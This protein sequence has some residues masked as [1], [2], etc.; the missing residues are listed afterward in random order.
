[1]KKNKILFKPYDNHE[2][3][4]VSEKQ[5]KE[6]LDEKELNI[7]NKEKRYKTRTGIFKIT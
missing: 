3:N 7:L 5:V 4:S 1:M 2:F 6:V